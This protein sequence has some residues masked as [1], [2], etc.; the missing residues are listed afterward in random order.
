MV[1]NI[2]DKQCLTLF[3]DISKYKSNHNLKSRRTNNSITVYFYPTR[4]FIVKIDE[5]DELN[6]LIDN[7]ECILQDLL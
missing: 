6:I 7:S 2:C 3:N 1:K 5:L 4:I